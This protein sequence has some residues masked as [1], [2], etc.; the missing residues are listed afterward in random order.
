[1][2]T[3][4]SL[5]RRRVKPSRGL[6]AAHFGA[7]A[8]VPPNEETLRMRCLLAA[9][10]IGLAMPAAAA[11]LAVTV[12]YLARIATPPGAVLDVILTAPGRDEPVAMVRVVDP[13]NPPVPV[14]LPHDGLPV[15]ATVRASLRLPDGT[16]FFAGEVSVEPGKN[17]AEVM[18]RP[19]GAPAADSVLVGPRWRLFLLGGSAVPSLPDERA[20]P[21]LV[22]DGEGRVAGSSGCNRMGAGYEAGSGGALRFSRG[23]GTMMA[24]EPAVMARERAVFDLLAKV[25]TARIDG[26]RLHL[27]GG[28][29]VLAVLVAE[30]TG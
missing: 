21:Y 15:A 22:F 29:A 25:E 11:D 9:L 28:G 19:A 13:G 14:A 2:A 16:A 30:P 27:S 23:F 26:D 18:M 10:L 3:L 1:M 7:Q 4:V 6:G 17:T 8:V 20:I 5:R 24:C 12:A